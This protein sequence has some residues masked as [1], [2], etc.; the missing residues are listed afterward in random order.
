MPDV[1]QLMTGAARARAGARAPE[2]M[3]LGL[4]VLSCGVHGCGLCRVACDEADGECAGLTPE[5]FD[6][7]DEAL[8][9]WRQRAAEREEPCD[10]P[11]PFTVVGECAEQG[12]RFL[13]EGG[14]FTSQ[15]LIYDADSGEFLGYVTYS[16]LIDPVCLGRGYWPRLVGCP[17]G[18]VTEVLCGTALSV[19]DERGFP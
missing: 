13:Y 1:R 7:F 6:G 3:I 2:V 15:A 9:Q 14:G 18:V 5:E 8:A 11:F 17:D 4:L 19:G 10:E 12:R 16:D